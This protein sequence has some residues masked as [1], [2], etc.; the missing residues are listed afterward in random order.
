MRLLLIFAP[1]TDEEMEW[2]Q[3]NPGLTVVEHTF[4]PEPSGSE[5]I[6]THQACVKR[7]M[8]QPTE[9]REG[10]ASSLLL[11]YVT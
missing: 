8:S 9:P 11:P 4:E 7:V 1:L 6:K 5:I 3:R 2:V 10:V